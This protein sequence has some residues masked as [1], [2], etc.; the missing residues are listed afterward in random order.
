[1]KMKCEI[2]KKR[3][4]VVDYCEGALA[5]SHG[6]K[7]WICR[8]CYIKILENTIKNC[9]KGIKEQEKLIAGGKNESKRT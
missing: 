6:F 2:C 5:F 9:E 4:G 1:M 8:L 3:E 7:T